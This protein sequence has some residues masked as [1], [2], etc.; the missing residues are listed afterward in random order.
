MNCAFSPDDRFL[1]TTSVQ[2]VVRLWDIKNGSEF[3]VIAGHRGLV[4]HVAFSP[5]G[6]RLLTASH[7]GTARLWDIDG[8]LTTSL[9]HPHP[10]TFAAF[11]PDGMRI[12]TGG[13]DAV[14]H[15]WDVASGREALQLE[16]NSGSIQDATFSPDRASR[17]HGFFEW[18]H[19][20]VGRGERA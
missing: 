17:C 7:D 11:S 5:D 16:T 3:A 20:P 14:A 19:Y 10:P 18:P 2:N 12:I 1:A 8:L 15:I 4:E 13:G 6:S 9:R